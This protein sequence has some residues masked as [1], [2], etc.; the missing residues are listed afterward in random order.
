MTQAYLK[1]HHPD[2]TFICPNLPSYPNQALTVLERLVSDFVPDDCGVIGSSLGGYWANILAERYGFR[3]VLVNPS[4][5]PWTFAAA[6]VGEVIK[7]YYSD[8]EVRLTG[9][10]IT[11][12]KERKPEVNQ[13]ALYWLLAQEGDETLDYCDAVAKFDGCR[14][15]VIPNGN[16][17][18][19]DYESWLPKITQFLK[20]GA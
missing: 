9:S 7:H 12:L 13:K 14:Q 2:W 17:A 3:S 4:V 11:F 8:E 15:T 1:R 18:F 10:D 6:R 16:H 20:S 19:E 5:A